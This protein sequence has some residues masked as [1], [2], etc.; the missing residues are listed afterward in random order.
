MQNENPFHEKTEDRVTYVNGLGFI[1]HKN[2][3]IISSMIRGNSNMLCLCAL[4]YY[5][6]SNMLILPAT[7]LVYML[8]ADIQINFYTGLIVSTPFCRTTI[9]F[10]AHSS[11]LIFTTGLCLLPNRRK[12]FAAK[13][14]KRPYRGVTSL[15]V[16]MTIAV[17]LLGTAIGLGGGMLF[18]KLGIVFQGT[19]SPIK[20]ITEMAIYSFVLLMIYAALQEVFFRGIA[21]SVLRRFGDGFAIIATSLLFALWA[22]SV[23]E[24][25]TYF[26]ISLA[27]SY[28]TIRS[29]SVYTAI[30]SRLCYKL[31]IFLFSLCYGS[32]ERSLAEVIIMLS[33]ILLVLFAAYS[34]VTFIKVDRHAFLLKSP[35]D[36]V[37]LVVKLSVFASS[38]VFII[39]G[40]YQIAKLLQSTQIIG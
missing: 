23:A 18:K 16:P 10:L 37:K 4:L 33:V 19:F 38:V 21:L 17:G 26:F 30:I 27:L 12:V 40:V 28:F 14:F 22:G 20:G 13:P 34:F 24:I 31:V 15:A 2:S 35:Q 7:Y 32:L 8:G 3:Q 29:G 9:L 1:E 39:F 11:A 36:N 6:L 5:L 25:I